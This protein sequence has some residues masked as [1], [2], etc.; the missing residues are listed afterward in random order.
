M[1]QKLEKPKKRKGYVAR[2][3]EL[4]CCEEVGQHLTREIRRRRKRDGK[5][6]NKSRGGGRWRSGLVVPSDG[7]APATV[8]ASNNS[9][10]WGPRM[11][12]HFS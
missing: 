2:R 1:R 10:G 9:G 7:I 6:T 4:R 3:K 5:K 11:K 12:D 8:A